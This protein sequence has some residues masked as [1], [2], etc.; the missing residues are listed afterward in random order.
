[1]RTRQFTMMQTLTASGSGVALLIAMI[2]LPVMTKA[3]PPCGEW[4]LVATP[5]R[6]DKTN[7]LSAV[8]AHSATDAWAVGLWRDGSGVHGPLAMRWDGTNWSA[9]DLPDTSKLGS[10]PAT[11]GVEAASNGDVWLVGNITTKY[12]TYNLPLVLRWRDGDWDFVDTVT[13][14]P[15]TEYPYAA[16]GGT[17]AEAAALSPDDIWAV[18]Q[19]AGFGDGKATTVPLAVHWDG[20]SWTEVDVPRV[21]NRHHELD[22][23]VAISSDDVWAVGD[24]R[25][26]AGA[27]HAITYHWDGTEW[28]HIKSP[29][30]DLADSGLDDVAAA[31]PNDVWALGGAADA[32]VVLMHWDGTE[33][34]LAEAPP[35]SGGSLAVLGPDDVWV[36]GWNGFW[37]W[38]GSAWTEVPSK[39]DGATYVIRGGGMEIVGDCNIWCVG[40]WTLEDGITGYTLAEELTAAAPPVRVG[41]LN[42]DDRID[43]N[44][45]DPFVLALISRDDY[46]SL[47]PG[48]N[49]L[50]GDVNVDDRVN[51]DDIDGFVECLINGGCG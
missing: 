1:M 22:D 47:Y 23:V 13:L 25:N 10:N 42:C 49:W 41:D 2:F 18:G 5:N 16:R 6:G 37:H 45:I 19:A 14:R 20:S 9:T 38:D 39:I 4:E 31:G 50:N 21:A 34:S 35:N 44:D 8:T 24:Y 7:W 33:W 26:I 29:I 43:F 30:E 27:F 11:D 15:Q 17:L 51:F 36:S 32:G 28:S 48:C 40:F 3:A 46:E 12:P